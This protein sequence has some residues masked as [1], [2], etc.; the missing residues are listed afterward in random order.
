MADAMVQYTRSGW[1]TFYLVLIKSAKESQAIICEPYV[2]RGTE[3]YQGWSEA[4]DRLPQNTRSSIVALVCDGHTGLVNCA[5]KHGWLIQRCHFHLIARLQSRRSKWRTSRHQKEGKR[6]Y[7]LVN[8]VLTS[9]KEKAVLRALNELEAIGWLSS[10]RELEMY[11]SGFV[12]NYADFRT[13]LKYPNLNLPK[14][15][16]A[17]EPFIGYIQKF[18]QR[19][20]G[21]ATLGSLKKWIEALIKYKKIAKCNGS[22]NQPN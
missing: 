22:K 2:K 14:T 3:V 8:L 10:S 4:L 15:S 5:K 17:I 9:K 7:E 20:R 16:N 1:Y 13:Y 11:L 19:T 21:F 12:K 6:I 18:R